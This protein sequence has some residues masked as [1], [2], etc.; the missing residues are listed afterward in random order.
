MLSD[1]FYVLLVVIFSG[2]ISNF[3]FWIL[4]KGKK[5]FWISF[6]VCLSIS[7]FMYFSSCK[8]EKI[9]E[10]KYYKQV[11][12]IPYNNGEWLIEDRYVDAFKR[13]AAKEGWT[14]YWWDFYRDSTGKLYEFPTNEKGFF[15][16]IKLENSG[17]CL[18]P[19]ECYLICGKYWYLNDEQH[20][21]FLHAL[22]YKDKFNSDDYPR[23]IF[24][25]RERSRQ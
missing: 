25:A 19:V 8:S 11:E 13:V 2:I 1:F 6:C 17:V 10:Q 9:R 4:D 22:S 18:T 24:V 15:D 12:K 7:A 14:Y 16:R 23:F 3:V 20:M 5:I 21:D